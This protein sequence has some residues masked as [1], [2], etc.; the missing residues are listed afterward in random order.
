MTQPTRTSTGIAYLTFDAT[1][2]TDASMIIQQKL[3]L[4]GNTTAQT[5]CENAFDLAAG[6]D[7]SGALLTDS[8]I[9]DYYSNHLVYLGSND[10]NVQ[11][12]F[13]NNKLN[14]SI[15]QNIACNAYE[16]TLGKNNQIPLVSYL[17]QEPEPEPEPEPIPEPEP[18]PEPIP[19]PEPEPEPGINPYTL[20]PL[21]VVAGLSNSN[22]NYELFNLGV[23]TNNYAVVGRDSG[24]IIYYTTDNGINWTQSSVPAMPSNSGDRDNKIRS[25]SISR[26]GKYSVFLNRGANHGANGRWYSNYYIS[27][28]YGANYSLPS[29]ATYHW[30]YNINT[31]SEVNNQNVGFPNSGRK[32]GFLISNDG[33]TIITARS[34]WG[35]LYVKTSTGNNNKYW[36][37]LGIGIGNGASYTSL[38]G[39]AN[40]TKVYGVT[41]NGRFCIYDES[42][43]SSNTTPYIKQGS[44]W[45]AL[46]VTSTGVIQSSE[47]T[48]KGEIQH[49][50][51]S[52]DGEIVLFG[53]EGGKLHLS[54]DGGATFSEITDDVFTGN[55]N[56]NG[57][58]V[59]SDGKIMVAITDS[60]SSPIYY[61]DDN[62][63]KWQTYTDTIVGS[64]T[65]NMI[66]V[67][68]NIIVINTTS[69]SYSIKIE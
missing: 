24:S 53:L 59:S 43:R 65:I 55:Y 35:I 7:I 41:H 6:E 16:M 25:L 48:N 14:S 26:N 8:G 63:D 13:L 5:F 52:E 2:N 29:N 60:A 50:A 28:D 10:V 11:K 17:E 3:D 12:T 30:G 19:E 67:N 61:Y 27:S 44:N 69:N 58:A 33:N 18:E 21:G 45:Q 68:N 62:L 47:P 34:G 9:T 49:I 46:W 31:G 56:W 37:Y 1:L 15:A 20:T 54:N 36:T 40:L 64:T 42:N 22:N 39:N 23:S 57:L 32:F 66:G 38:A 4:S 51:C